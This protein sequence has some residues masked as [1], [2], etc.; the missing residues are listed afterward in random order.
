MGLDRLLERLESEVT[1]V[2]GLHDCFIEDFSVTPSEAALP[3]VTELGRLVTPVTPS[4]PIP[5]LGNARE[6]NDVTSVT[7]VTPLNLS[8]KD[9]E[10]LCS[11][12]THASRFGNCTIP[13]EAGLSDKFML[14]SHPQGGQ[15]CETYQRKLNPLVGEA[16]ALATI[17]LRFKA[18]S[19]TEFD[20]LCE[21]VRSN[22]DDENFLHEWIQLIGACQHNCG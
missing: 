2:T 9:N 8:E 11:S 4:N 13:V 16:I 19:Q 7:P 6:I 10:G 15:G 18:I 1:E 3:E 22:E 20:Q 21:S 14:I 5:T 17:A 12:C